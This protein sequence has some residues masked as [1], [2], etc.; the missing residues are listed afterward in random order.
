[1]DLTIFEFTDIDLLLNRSPERYFE[2]LNGD[3]FYEEVMLE[4]TVG[5]TK[6]NIFQRLWNLI[7]KFFAWIS[8]AIKKLKFWL[9]GGRKVDVNKVMQDNAITGSDKNAKEFFDK[10][11]IENNTIN[12]SN[13][14][15]IRGIDAIQNIAAK[16]FVKDINGNNVELSIPVII[17]GVKCVC[18][19]KKLTIYID[20]DGGY[21]SDNIND[22]NSSNFINDN[23]NRN[24]GKQFLAMVTHAIV[25][26]KVFE[27]NFVDQL[28]HVCMMFKAE[29]SVDVNTWKTLDAYIQEIKTAYFNSNAPTIISQKDL[30]NFQ[31]SIDKCQKAIEEVTNIQRMMSVGGVDTADP[32][33]INR[34]ASLLA[35][36]QIGINALIQS[37]SSAGTIEP[38][39]FNSVNDP[40]KLSQIVDQLMQEGVTGKYME[41]IVYFISGPDLCGDK[42][43]GDGNFIA[44]ESRCILF[45]KTNK[46]IVYKVGYNGWGR[47]SNKSEILSSDIITSRVPTLKEYIA[48]AAKVPGNNSYA[49]IM[50]ERIDGNACP[51]GS[52]W[53]KKIS[54]IFNNEFQK[55]NINY[56]IKDFH[57]NNMIEAPG[58]S[59]PIVI[60]YGWG[61]LATTSSRSIA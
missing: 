3:Q 33:I 31:I 23:K 28:I 21:S 9:S 57:R 1:M 30:D 60:D 27:S 26:S 19:D 5:A 42:N 8:R 61:E 10:A 17:N 7:K 32:S 12:K 52:N 58:K 49:V 38:K 15:N 29:R 13:E 45:P 47:S 20:P 24:F 2:D 37:L 55:H 34:A 56:T 44:G 4:A 54:S 25:N 40:I 36:F 16:F 51:I 11:K 48:K 35:N 50:Q 41:S 53:P 6:G 39:Y 18:R 43:E 22:N 59:H 14:K 46:K